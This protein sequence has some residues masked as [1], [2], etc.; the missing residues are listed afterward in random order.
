MPEYLGRLVL[1]LLLLVA[2]GLLICCGQSARLPDDG[3]VD[4]PGCRVAF[5]VMGEGSGVPV[6][7]IHGGPGSSSCIYPS[8]LTGIAAERPVIIYDQLG[9]G[10]SD[11]IADL[12]RHGVL[13]LVPR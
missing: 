11:R 7:V 2:A 12:E 6:L 10:Y 8:T 1:G 9:S 5:R 4:V 13:D 3:F